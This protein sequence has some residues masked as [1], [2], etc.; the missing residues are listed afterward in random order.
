MSELLKRRKRV[1]GTA[2]AVLIALCLLL[3]VF[4]LM[5]APRG[6]PVLALLPAKTAEAAHPAPPTPSRQIGT[7]ARIYYRDKVVVLMYHNISPTYHGRGTITPE[8][9]AAEISALVQSGYHIIPVQELAAFLQKR[10]QVPP[11]AVVITFDDGYE[12]VYR[13]AYPVLK[14]F[15]APATVFLI[16]SYIGKKEGF[17]SW[18]QVREMAASGL[19]TFGGHTFNAHYGA[20]TGPHTTAPATV[21]HIYDF[22]SGR[23]ETATAYRTRLF[24]DS[25]RAQ[26]LFTQELGAPTPYFAYPYGAFTPALDEILRTAGYRYFF[27]TL[28][29]ANQPGQDPYH[30]YRIN[31]G[32]PWITPERLVSAVRYVA[33]LYNLPHRMPHMWLPRWAKDP[34]LAYLKANVPLSHPREPQRKLVNFNLHHA[35]ISD[36]VSPPVATIK[37]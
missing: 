15:R 34:A 2:L 35:R 7:A 16:A 12:G 36:R 19:L 14:E 9:F 33:W 1:I 23:K 5:A 6:E 28:G 32:A 37:R 3:P 30:I 31:A 11:N 25:Q 24:A 21:A 27:T 20:P 4:I 22:A 26:A 18:P 29:G 10:A 17:L 13:Y 8:T